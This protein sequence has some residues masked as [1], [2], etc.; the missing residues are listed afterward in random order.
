M[1]V[2]HYPVTERYI[3][4]VSI[5]SPSSRQKSDQVYCP[6]CRI[7]VIT[8]AAVQKLCLNNNNK[9]IFDQR[10]SKESGQALYASTDTFNSVLGPAG[11]WQ[12]LT[13]TDTQTV[14]LS[15]LQA[16]I[17]QRLIHGESVG[18][19][20]TGGRWLHSNP[21]SRAEPCSSKSARSICLLLLLE[22]VTASHTVMAETFTHQGGRSM[23]R[24]SWCCY[25][26]ASGGLKITL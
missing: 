26:I 14:G 24:P 19:G 23:L 15:Q 21:P 12:K 9:E 13:V 18:L 2:V 5:L 4:R 6:K 11:V 8:E 17:Q 22:E 10:I 7:T 25:T 3:Q 20:V 16:V 1:D